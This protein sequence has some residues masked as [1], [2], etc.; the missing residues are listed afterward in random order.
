MGL[1]ASWAC[2]GRVWG[3]L[4]QL[5][6]SFG[7]LLGVSWAP[8]RRMLGALGRIWA[9]MG[10]SGLDFSGFE[11]PPAFEDNALVAAGSPVCHSHGHSSPPC[12]AA[13]RALCAHGIG[14]KIGQ[15]GVQNQLLFCVDSVVVYDGHQKGPK[16][17]QN[18][19]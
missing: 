9:L 17:S 10:A 19:I 7:A 3:A 5:L 4:E 13:V 12:S 16:A 2:L 15:L 1:G 14:T 6:G 8:F 18:L 11:V